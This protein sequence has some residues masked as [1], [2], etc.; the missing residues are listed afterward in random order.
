MA[1]AFTSQQIGF[2]G[3]GAM[4]EALI[5][6]VC[7]AGVPAKQICVS[8]P[9]AERRS[10]LE[11]TFG[12]QTFCENAEVVSASDLVILAVKPN[13][14]AEVLRALAATPNLALENPLWISIAAGV[15]LS[16]ISQ[17]LP[18]SARVLR[19]MPNTPA[20]V[21]A[22]ATAFFAN[23]HC[24][25][26]DRALANTLFEAVGIAWEAPSEEL[27]DAVTGLSGSGPAYV[28]YFLMELIAAG[29]SVGLPRA[30]AE[31]LSFQTVLGSA[32][33]ALETGVAPQELKVRVT[34]P[35]GTTMAGLKC[36]E[37]GRLRA[38]LHEAVA[39]ATKRSK[40]LGRD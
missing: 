30:A 25:P 13:L 24:T 9:S 7:A 36:L 10:H 27:L 15:T 38:A 32:K 22:G 21:R 3:G 39:A 26:R 11:K 20:L 40:E 31:R 1:N 18:A 33:M 23:P 8:D 29:E 5:G 16:R 17:A 4:A 35:G 2:L 19:A 37:D 34:S 6:A 28:F 14:V 12:V